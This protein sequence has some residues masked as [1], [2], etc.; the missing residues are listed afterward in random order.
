MLLLIAFL[1]SYLT[2]CHVLIF[3][4]LVFENQFPRP[5]AISLG[6]LLF[7]PVMLVSFLVTALA[8]RKVVVAMVVAAANAAAWLLSAS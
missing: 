5:E 8:R 3:T 2:A 7:I 1:F 4:S 6:L